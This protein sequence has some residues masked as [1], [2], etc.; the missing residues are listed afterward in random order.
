MTDDLGIGQVAERTGLTVHAIRFYEKEGLLVTP[1]RRDRGGRRVFTEDDVD[2][3][4]LCTILR[5]AGMPLD[6]IRRY[7]RLVGAGDGTEAERLDLLRRHERRL[8]EQQVQLDR[9]RDLIG[10]KIGVYEDILAG[11]ASLATRHATDP[12]RSGGLA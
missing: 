5:G 12:S 7:T 4:T 11:E 8:D 1:V 2:W 6:E 10:F 3:L 9:C